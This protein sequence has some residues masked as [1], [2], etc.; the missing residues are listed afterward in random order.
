MYVCISVPIPMEYLST[1]CM[2]VCMQLNSHVRMAVCGFAVV[3]LVE[4]EISKPCVF[5]N[6]LL[7]LHEL[8]CELLLPLLLAA[9][10]ANAIF[11]IR[12]VRFDAV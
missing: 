10:K 1:H 5:S 2:Y 6:L 9:A 12:I 11:T 4:L 8:I 3:A 7:L